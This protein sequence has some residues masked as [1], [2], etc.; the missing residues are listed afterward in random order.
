M[1][2]LEMAQ[3][4]GFVCKKIEHIMRKGENAGYQHFLF[5]SQCFQRPP[6]LGLSTTLDCLGKG[7]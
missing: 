6:P 2:K 3:T 4:I 5:Y 7:L 1:D